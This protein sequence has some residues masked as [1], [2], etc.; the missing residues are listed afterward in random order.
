MTH[1]TPDSAI[2]Q[3]AWKAKLLRIFEHRPGVLVGIGL[4]GSGKTTILKPLAT[5]LGA[6]YLNRDE[7]RAELTGDPTNHTREPQVTRL[8]EQRL[9]A[10]LLAKKHVI[11]DATYAKRKDRTSI[12]ELSRLYGAQLVVGL[13][14][15]TGLETSIIRNNLRE[16]RVPE[17]AIQRMHHKMVLSPPSMDEGFDYLLHI[18]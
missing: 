10:A 14:I 12:I 15:N 2:Q 1:Q 17:E 6:V 9:A 3:P 5:E 11:V 16:R 13:H 18:T 4:P 7:I 8:G